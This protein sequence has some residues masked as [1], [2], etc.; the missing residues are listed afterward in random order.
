MP[1]WACTTLCC[2]DNIL[3]LCV[4]FRKN[5]TKVCIATLPCLSPQM[6]PKHLRLR[7][8]KPLERALLRVGAPF[9]HLMA[10]ERAK[11]RPECCLAGMFLTEFSI[12]EHFTCIVREVHFHLWHWSKVQ[13]NSFIVTHLF[14]GIFFQTGASFFLTQF[15]ID[16]INTAQGSSDFFFSPARSISQCHVFQTSWHEFPN[17]LWSIWNGKALFFDARSW[18]TLLNFLNR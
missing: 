14:S 6:T 16:K 3:F 2:S 5:L 18:P 1:T 9:S 15:S 8:Q 11:C 13:I 17:F 12:Q 10:C 7:L 4:L